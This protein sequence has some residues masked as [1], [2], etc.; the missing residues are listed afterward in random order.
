MNSMD[1]VISMKPE[2]RIPYTVGEIAASTRNA[3]VG[4]PFGSNL[5]SADYVDS[6]VPVIRGQNMG[7][8]RWV[9]GDFVFVS[10][11]KAESLSANIAKPGDLM[12]TQRGTL[13]QVAIVPEGHYDK[14][15]VSQS[16]MKLTVDCAKANTLFLYYYFT[17]KE[18]QEYIKSNSIQTGVPHTNLGILRD[19]K[20]LL[21][22]L[23]EQRVI[24]RILGSIDDKIE[25]N[26][27]MNETLED[28]ARAVF[29]SWFVDFDPVSARVKGRAPEGMDEEMAALFPDGFEA[30]LIGEIPRGWHVRPM[31]EVVKVLGGGTPS[32]KEPTYWDG[33]THPFCTPKDMSLLTSSVLLRD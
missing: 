32:T 22:P 7:F 15:V 25:A 6:G 13:G 20:L 18:Q 21:P 17:S 27:A 24:A 14:Y 3:L 26:H 19:T 12:F 33:G 23:P 16:Q 28:M 9:M 29:K 10:P 2:G 5:V 31:G 4:G 1:R 30:S 11:E 8:G